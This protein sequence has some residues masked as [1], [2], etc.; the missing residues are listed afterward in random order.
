MF[1]LGAGLSAALRGASPCPLSQSQV[2]RARRQ[3]SQEKWLAEALLAL[4]EMG[5][6]G[7]KVPPDTPLTMA[8]FDAVRRHR[9]CL[10]ET[11]QAASGS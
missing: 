2:R 5:G 9:G 11:E 8:Q 10:W 7:V 3:R 1:G 4:N 6:Q